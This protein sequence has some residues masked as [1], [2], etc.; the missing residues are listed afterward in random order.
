MSVRD[1]RE[2][3][4][5]LDRALDALNDERSPDVGDAEL[6]SLIDTAHIVRRLRPPAEPD[7]AFVERLVSSVATAAR[8]NGTVSS[9]HLRETLPLQFQRPRER[10]ARSLALIAAALRTIGIC[11]LAGM[12]AGGLIGGL[13]GRAVMR[14]SGYMYEQSNPGQVVITSSSEEP[15][16][17]ISLRGT[18]DLV[19]E[20]TI[21]NGLMGGLLYLVLA[22][23]LPRRRGARGVA[24]AVLLLLAS[25]WI[26]FDSGN[27][28]FSELG[29]PYLN[30][31]MFGG[32]IAAFGLMV[33]WLADRFALVR[34]IPPRRAGARAWGIVTVALGVLG[35]LV[36]VLISLGFGLVFAIRSV[37]SVLQ[38]DALMLA[39]TLAILPLLAL[40]VLRI[41]ALFSA[42]RFLDTIRRMPRYDVASTLLVPLIVIGGAAVT[43]RAIVEILAG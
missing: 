21:T 32:L 31:T 4:E 5:R 29:N 37:E 7:E 26:V 25:G 10:R 30:V 23:Y 3:N 36:L 19:V 24:F 35:L 42:T 6:E 13:G 38:A 16:G 11:V 2:F 41:A 27:T 39:S 17:Q 8:Q 22:P 18:W 28:D 1:W 14:V 9:A 43:L 12:I 15:V 34:S 40:I 20:M 33:P